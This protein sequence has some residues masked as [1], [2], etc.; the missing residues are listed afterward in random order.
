MKK[1]LIMLAA[2]C[3]LTVSGWA[4][5]SPNSVPLKRWSVWA[6]AESDLTTA[7]L[8]YMLTPHVEV[9]ALGTW[10][11][12]REQP[13]DIFGIYGVYH[14][15]YAVE[16][17]QFIPLQG[18]PDTLTAKPFV[19]VEITLDVQNEGDRTMAGPSAGF[20]VQDLLVLKYTYR[21]ASSKLAEVQN[22]EHRFGI[23]LNFRF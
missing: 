10:R 13:G 9:G 11:D 20:I 14:F 1:T 5:E 23:G 6:M 2:L 17:P 3:L 16:I 12:D 4:A 21:M 22:D 7:Q 18:L 19:G 8:G 15:D